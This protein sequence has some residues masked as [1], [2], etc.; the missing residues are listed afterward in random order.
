MIT[1]QVFFPGRHILKSGCVSE[2]LHAKV[3]GVTVFKVWLEQGGVTRVSQVNKGHI[4]SGKE[5]ADSASVSLMDLPS[6]PQT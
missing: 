2:T 1:C 6:Q 3:Q 5:K 4:E